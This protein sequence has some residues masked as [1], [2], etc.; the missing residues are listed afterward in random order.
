MDEDR[1]QNLTS[2]E[3]MELVALRRDKRLR[4]AAFRLA[5]PGSPTPGPGW[6][7]GRPDLVVLG[8]HPGLPGTRSVRH[9]VL[10]HAHSPVAIVPSS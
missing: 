1:K 6:P 7:V 10:N 9:A 8:R 4:S 3:R 2:D 5:F